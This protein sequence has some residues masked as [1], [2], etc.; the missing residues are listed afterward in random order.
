[1]EINEPVSKISSDIITID[2]QISIENT[3]RVM[4]K[5]N[6]R[7]IAIIAESGVEIVDMR[8]LLGY[9]CSWEE[10]K[11]NVLDTPID[12]LPKT[13]VEKISGNITI[14]QAAKILLEKDL[15]CAIYE[16]KIVTPWDFV[17]KTLEP[18]VI[19]FGM[20]DAAILD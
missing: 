4:E 7:K 3:L 12:V 10:G 14:S 5:K 11:P 1:M 17:I 9:L 8:S 6:L 18:S 20:D 13:H 19:L 15:P 2:K 16:N